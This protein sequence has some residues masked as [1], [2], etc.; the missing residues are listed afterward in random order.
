MTLSLRAALALTAL[1]SVLASPALAQ[2]F[3]Q[4]F[5]H[6]FGTTVVE[7]APERV[8]S[9]DYGGQDDLLALGIVPVA[10]RYWYGDYPYGTW[11]W[12]Q[13]ALGDS[14]FEMIEGDLNI[15][16]VAAL[17]PDVILAQ[18]SGITED[19]YALLSQ[20]APVI[21][22]EAQYD[23]YSTPWDVRIRN[24]AR[25]V[26]QAEEAEAQIGAIEDRIAQIA[27]D[28]PEWQGQTAAITSYWNDGPSAYTSSDPRSQI[29]AEMGFVTPP[30]I[31]E[32]AGPGTFYVELSN[33]DVSPFDADVVVWLDDAGAIQGAL[34]MPLRTTMRAHREGREVYADD[35]LSGAFSFA[36]LLSMPYML[37]HL[38]PQLEAAAD[39]DPSTPVP[40]AVEI[41]LAPAAE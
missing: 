13:A 29:L 11:P 23:D 22:A 8:V 10:V 40:E 17:A 18:Y 36:S 9:L 31:D 24:M 37:D 21:A 7:A 20:I 32:A 25:A 19:E 12:A 3:P 34:A 27:A 28:H 30:A 35:V 15:E 16:Q 4:T 39:G 33:E 41:G 14:T 38:V 2:D 5:E 1:A 6:R 26:G